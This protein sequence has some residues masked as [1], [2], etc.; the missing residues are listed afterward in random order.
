MQSLLRMR[1]CF[2]VAA[3]VLALPQVAW[4]QAPLTAAS[5]AARYKA[6][7]RDGLLELALVQTGEG[8]LGGR[9]GTPHG[10]YEIRAQLRPDGKLAGLARGGVGTLYFA[11][12]LEEG[13]L[14]LL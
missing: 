8:T 7:M 11:G 1:L 3:I 10:V 2:L 12:E 5:Y 13:R 14:R 4:S 6:L 9:L